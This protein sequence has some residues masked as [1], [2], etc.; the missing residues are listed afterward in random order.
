M[1]F[2]F[3]RKA[4]VKNIKDSVAISETIIKVALELKGYDVVVIGVYAPS[5]DGTVDV[6]DEHDDK[7]SQLLD[8]VSN[9]KEVFTLGDSDAC[10]GA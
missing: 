9:R 2:H 3:I 4:L 7:L 5:N 1:C 8:T 6:N 10:V